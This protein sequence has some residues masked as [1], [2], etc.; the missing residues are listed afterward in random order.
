MIKINGKKMSL[1]QAFNS[2]YGLYNDLVLNDPDDL[3]HFI[4][5]FKLEA[6]QIIKNQ[7]Q[8]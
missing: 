1:V 8:D 5:A 4:E 2:G 6:N 3:D 7:S